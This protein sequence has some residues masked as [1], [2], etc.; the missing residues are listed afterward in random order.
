M[1]DFGILIRMNVKIYKTTEKYLSSSE[2]PA[3][4]IGRALLRF[5]ANRFLCSVLRYIRSAYRLFRSPGG[6]ESGCR[7]DC[8]RPHRRPPAPTCAGFPADGRVR[9]RWLRR[10]WFP[11]AEC[12]AAVPRR[13]GGKGCRADESAAFRPDPPPQINVRATVPPLS[14]PAGRSR[15]VRFPREGRREC[16]QGIPPRSG[17]LPAR[18]V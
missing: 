10:W 17:T 1:A 13:R 6:R 15:G 2:I 14:A 3:I 11:R 12:G 9:R 18:R 4:K 16:D 7:P 5:A 8:D